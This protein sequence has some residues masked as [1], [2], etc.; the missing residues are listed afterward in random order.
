MR[1]RQ[2]CRR[3]GLPSPRHHLRRLHLPIFSAELAVADFAFIAI[4]IIK[5]RGLPRALRH[6]PH[7]SRSLHYHLPP[8]L[9]RKAGY[10]RL[11]P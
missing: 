3:L 4:A 8:Q 6:L 9:N 10:Q 5:F 7:R 11:N 2:G 1:N